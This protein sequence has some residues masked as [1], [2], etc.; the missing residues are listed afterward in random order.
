MKG[1]SE[2]KGAAKYLIA[3]CLIFVLVISNKLFDVNSINNLF[4]DSESILGGHILT[5]ASLIFILR[6]V[7]IV[8][9]VLPGTYCSVIAGYFYGIKAGLILIFV[10]DITSCS[11]SFFLSR[12]FGRNFVS[13][14]LGAK[15]MQRVE[16]ISQRYLEQNIFFM[17]GFLM[18][19]FFDFVCYAIGLTKVSWKK[20]MPALIISILISD[21]PFVAS[22][23]T[24]RALN[25]VTLR[26]LLNGDV[27]ALSGGYLILFIIIIIAIFALGALSHFFKAK[28][29]DDSFVN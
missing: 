2:I 6:S 7:S 9:P 23:Y 18:T 21:L 24:L 20:F 13:R 25:G 16:N 1:G 17:T 5:A 29:I 27:Q 8:I 22:G 3:A 28:S 10:A 4:D 11:C 15:Q 26:Q 12:R 14:I 19:Q